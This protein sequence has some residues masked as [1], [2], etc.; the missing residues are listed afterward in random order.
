MGTL[1]TEK[2]KFTFEL[3]H[4]IRDENI[5]TFFEPSM[6]HLDFV[7]YFKIMVKKGLTLSATQLKGLYDDTSQNKNTEVEEFSE[8]EV[9]KQILDVAF[10]G[11]GENFLSYLEKFKKFICKRDICVLGDYSE[12]NKDE[13]ASVLTPDLIDVFVTLD[14][15][16]AI[17]KE[18]SARFFV[19]KKL[20]QS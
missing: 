5:L 9:G 4:R 3:S 1:T 7:S 14:E 10:T 18:Y 13:S 16:D 15:F 8:L 2:Q 6:K 20:I 11:L 19:E 12:K 17:V